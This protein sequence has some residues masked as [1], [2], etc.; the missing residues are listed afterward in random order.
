[1]SILESFNYNDFY[2]MSD[3]LA[4]KPFIL[5]IKQNWVDI[6]KA[7]QLFYGTWQ[8]PEPIILQAI[9]GGQ[10]ADVLWTSLPPLLCI[11]QRLV[12][13]LFEHKFTGWGTFPVEVYDR[14][15]VSLAGYS[16]FSIKSYAGKQ[17]FSRCTIIMK[18]PVPGFSL[19]P[20]RFYIGTFFNE[21]KWDGSD[22]FRI[23]HAVMI[24][25]KRV[26]QEF[27]KNRITNVR[28]TPLLETETSESIY[29]SLKNS[30][31]IE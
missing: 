1:M 19:P 12:D 13:I 9:S 23:Q 3:P 14:K 17:D 24:V 27:K 16:G 10:V 7:N 6:P 4:T 21:T 25:R 28:F 5:H 30:G 26:M 31:L 18:P 11:S 15:G 2:K 22:I 8:P 20:V 29:K